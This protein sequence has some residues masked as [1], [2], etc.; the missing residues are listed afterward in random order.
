MGKERIVVIGSANMDLVAVTRK[1]PQAGETVFGRQFGMYPGGKGANQAVCC[2]KL[3][4]KV[5]FIGK[6]G[7]DVFREKLTE[8]MKA[9]GV[10][11]AHL[12]VDPHESTGIALI[13]VEESGQ[14]EIVV[15]PGSNMKLSAAD[16]E[17][18]RDVLKT[19]RV[20]LLQLEIPL[21][22]AAAVVASVRSQGCCIILNPAPARELPDSLLAQVDFLTPNES[23]LATLTGKPVTDLSAAREAAKVLLD[24]G[25]K[26]II[27]TLGS[28]G[29]LWVHDTIAEVFP[30]KEV[31]AV[32][33]TA[34]G[35]AF[36]GALACAVARGEAI[37]DAI[38]FANRVAAFAVTRMG[39]QSSMP[40]LKDLER[41]Q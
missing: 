18:K 38:R 25:V 13:L 6:T 8:S 29:C 34:A 1:F 4:A 40:T 30:A 10:N 41:F 39:A 24:R 16:I 17:A 14:N 36:N 21:E 31:K 2:A 33:T 26:N 37:S 35:D 9:A 3:G 15:V 7:E 5:D 22:T 11:L 27:I 23:E 20:V 28:Q 19:A 32:D 12:L